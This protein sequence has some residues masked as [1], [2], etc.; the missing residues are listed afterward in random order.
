[1]ITLFVTNIILDKRRRRIMA[2]GVTLVLAF[3]ITLLTLLPVS[4][5][6]GVPGTDKAHHLLGFAALTLPS[7]LLYPRSLVIVLP[8]SLLFGGAIELIQPYVGRQG[9][10][11]DFS[12]D[13]VG[14]LVGVGVGLALRTVT[15]AVVARQR[16]RAST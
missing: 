11:A 2:L 12:A 3:I 1:M 16:R 6:Q 8:C 5:P 7:A 4:A 10:F 14:A 15:I 9:E 13:A